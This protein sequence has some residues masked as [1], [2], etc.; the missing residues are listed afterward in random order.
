M[1][2]GGHQQDKDQAHQR[3]V[4]QNRHQA[5]QEFAAQE[6]IPLDGFGQNAVDRA[7]LDLLGD[8]RDIENDA[9]KDARQRNDA[10]PE[11]FG[12][13]QVTRLR[14]QAGERDSH[15]NDRETREQENQKNFAAHRFAEGAGGNQPD[16]IH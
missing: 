15:Q 2:L 4:Q 12:H 6:L 14:R 11:A 9:D 3:D 1:L 16:R 8:E 7:P 13:G 5:A 10:Q